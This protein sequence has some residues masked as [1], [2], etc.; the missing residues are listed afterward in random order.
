M[1]LAKCPLRISL[2]GGSTDTVSFLKK[3]NRGAVISFT[4]NLYTYVSIHQNN[5]NRYIVN[6]STREETKTI[7]E[8]KNDIVRECLKKFVVRPCT[9][10][11][12]TNILSSGSGLASSSSFIISMIKAICIFQNRKMSNK[13]ICDLSFEI[14]RIINPLAG[15]QDVYGCAVGNFKRIDFYLNNQQ[16]YKFLDL[17]FVLDKYKMYLVNTGVTRSSTKILRTLDVDKSYYLLSVVDKMEQAIANK[18]SKKFFQIFNQGWEIKKTTSSEIMNSENLSKLEQYLVDSK[19][20]SGIKL[21]GAGGG[22]Y[23]FIFVD[24][25]QNSQFKKYFEKGYPANPLIQV[26]IDSAGVVGTKI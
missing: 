16:A 20:I 21:C 23:F 2:V 7:E 19:M 13:N 9:V 11:F 3:F 1:I 10:S 22:G 24:K 5:I 4:S 14:E 8:I 6:C 26:D 25:K 15:Y 18:D 17:S 12:N